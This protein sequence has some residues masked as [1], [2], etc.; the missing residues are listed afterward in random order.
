MPLKAKYEYAMQCMITAAQ[1]KAL[2]Q[3]PY[4]F[5]PIFRERNPCYAK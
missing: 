2:L 3:F 1:L 5:L 4:S